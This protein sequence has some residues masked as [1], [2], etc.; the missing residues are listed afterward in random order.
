MGEPIRLG[1]IPPPAAISKQMNIEIPDSLREVVA[2]KLDELGWTLGG[3]SCL[4]VPRFTASVRFVYLIPKGTYP[5]GLEWDIKIWG[6]NQGKD[7]HLLV[8]SDETGHKCPL[9][10]HSGWVG[11][12]LFHCDNKNC[13]NH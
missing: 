13:Q 3:I 6:G 1:D 7:F 9:C 4:N 5:A 12:V 10:G 8:A 2:R 11:A